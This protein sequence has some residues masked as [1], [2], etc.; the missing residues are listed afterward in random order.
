M[1]EIGVRVSAGDLLLVR[2]YISDHHAFAAEDARIY[3]G[4]LHQVEFMF[5]CQIAE[6]DVHVG[7]TPD[8]WQTGVEW[9]PVS[10]WMPCPFTRRRSWSRCNA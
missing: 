3:D 8:D 2:D 9:V 1:E 7:K 5:R 10:D 6:G 4:G